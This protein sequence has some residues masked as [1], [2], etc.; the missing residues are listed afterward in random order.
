MRPD[1]SIVA[2]A[3]KIADDMLLC[4]LDMLLPDIVDRMDRR[5]T[6][7]N[8][9]HAPGSLRYFGMN[10]LPR[11]NTSVT[12]DGNDKPPGIQGETVS[13]CR[14]HELYSPINAL[15]RRSFPSLNASIGWVAIIVSTI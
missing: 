3:D 15:E 2:L 8:V 6:G 5:F 7:G 1:G 14:R 12:V 9:E 4:G 13:R 11:P 10:L